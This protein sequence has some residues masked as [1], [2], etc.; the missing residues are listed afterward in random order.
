MDSLAPAEFPHHPTGA[1]RFRKRLDSR[2]QKRFTGGMDLANADLVL[3]A[4]TF[5]LAM[6]GAAVV[7]AR[8]PASEAARLAAGIVGGMG[9]FVAASAPGVYRTLGLGAFV[10]EA[11]CLATPALVWLLAMREFRDDAPAGRWR[12]AV[13]VGLVVLT[14]PADFGRSGLG[15]LA[16]HP[17]LSQGLLLAGRVAAV[18]FV[19]AACWIAVA[20]WRADLVEERRRIRAGFVAVLGT[21]FAAMACSEFVFGGRGAP[22]EVLLVAHTALLGLAFATVLFAALG[23]IER[24]LSEDAP[25]PARQPLALVR[26]GPE[27]ELAQRAVEAMTAR[28]LWKRER[29]GIGDL[30]LELDAQEYRLRRAINRHLGY[31][32][33]NE[34]LHEYRLQAAAVRLADPAHDRLPVLTIALDC[35]YGSIGPFNRAF[36]A[37]YGITPS[38]Y[39]NA[40]GEGESLTSRRF[41]IRRD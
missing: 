25:R 35:G 13:P 3:R 20:H 8:S 41:R 9:A 34:F 23:G 16:G 14:M 4:A 39:R 26:D 21:A 30:A 19:L 17:S 1:G 33:F 27:A 22:L 7:V 38:Q 36:K 11:W 28:E 32:N 18:L 6:A 31:R 37:R 15:L 29:L 5:A 40:R 10:F 2:R 24:L 12:F